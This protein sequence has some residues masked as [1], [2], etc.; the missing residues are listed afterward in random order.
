MK[1]YM[2]YSRNAGS[3]FCAVL[4]FAHSTKEAKPLAWKSLRDFSAV[5]QYT[6]LAVKRIRHP[7]SVF[8]EANLLKL[9][10]GIAHVIENPASCK[11]CGQWGTELDKYGYC[12]SCRDRI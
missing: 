6:D 11:C 7:S 9:S 3:A 10:K 2:G 1:A 12:E 4:V 8:R 5:E